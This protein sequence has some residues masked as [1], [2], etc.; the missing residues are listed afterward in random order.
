MTPGYLTALRQSIRSSEKSEKSPH[1]TLNSLNSLFS[2]PQLERQGVESR[3]IS[4]SH[5][6]VSIAERSSVPKS[7]D[8]EKNEKSP[9]SY[10]PSLHA[11]RRR[12]PDF[13]EPKRWR[14][15]VEDGQRFLASWGE[16]AHALG[17]TARELFGL[18]TPPE[19]P[20]ACYSRL[21]R[22]D[23]TGLVWLL[24]GRPIVALTE[25]TAA[26]QG[27]TSVLTYRKLNKP[28]LGPL[29]DSLDDIGV[30]S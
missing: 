30:A 27:A 11:L 1:G 19:G 10:E 15:A 20:V 21:S 12:C 14:Q 13:V 23:E 7:A 9:P 17:W 5:E 8:C 28:A 18:H 2:H 25:T 24:R 26:I 4:Q 29:S 3:S 22:Y 6:S 16:Q